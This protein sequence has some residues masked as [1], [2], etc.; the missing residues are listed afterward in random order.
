MESA[1]TLSSVLHRCLGYA[2]E[3]LM[4]VRTAS[5]GIGGGLWAALGSCQRGETGKDA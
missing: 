1:D 5:D 4:H 3:G 2:P